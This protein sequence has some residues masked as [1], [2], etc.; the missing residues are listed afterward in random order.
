MVV[1]RGQQ[2]AAKI[3][4]PEQDPS[5]QLAS[6]MEYISATQKYRVKDDDPAEG[7]FAPEYLVP[8]KNVIW[9][10]EASNIITHKGG[11]VLAM[12][13]DCT[14]FYKATVVAEPPTRVDKYQL[15]FD[16]EATGQVR[17]VDR[18]YVFPWMP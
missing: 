8:A 18:C 11:E 5:W 7:Q 1:P 14:I 15:F 4:Q 2:V 12:Y 16:G 13:P 9:L 3:I 6:V 10:S 17:P